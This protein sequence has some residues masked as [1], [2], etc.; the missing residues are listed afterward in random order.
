MTRVSRFGIMEGS[1]VRA[2]WTAFG[3]STSIFFIC[4]VSPS[5][6]FVFPLFKAMSRISLRG[7]RETLQTTP[8]MISTKITKEDEDQ[9]HKNGKKYRKKLRITAEKI[10]P[11]LQETWRRPDKGQLGYKLPSHPTLRLVARPE[12]C[13]P[14]WRS[15]RRTRCQG[16]GPWRPHAWT[17]IAV[18]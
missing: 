13:Q 12:A 18:Q 6:K 9:E 14:Q 2:W 5:E 3:Q 7:S 4:N 1:S 10:Q 11:Q 16:T 8:T 15:R 17:L